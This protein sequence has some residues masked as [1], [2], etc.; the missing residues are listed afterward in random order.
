[1]LKFYFCTGLLLALYFTAFTQTNPVPQPLPYQQDFTALPATATTYPAGWQGWVL[2]PSTATQFRVTP[3]TGDKAL[4]ANGTAASTTGT[5]YNYNGKIGALNS[6][7]SGDQALVLAV[8]TTGQTGLQAGYTVMTI[9]NPYGGSNSRINEVVLQYRIGTTGN[10]TNVDG[11]LYQNNTTNQQS[12]TDPQNPLTVS[13]PLP[14]SCN[15]QP[16]VQL[17]WTSR[18]V[19]GSGSRPSFAIDNITIGNGS[20]GGADTTRPVV[21][22]LFPAT[23]ATGVPASAQP[24]IQFSE[25]VQKNTGVITVFDRTAQTS[26]TIAI[27]DSINAVLTGNTLAL[28]ARLKPLH[29][30]YILLDSAL[31]KDAAGNPFAGIRDSTAWTFT[32]GP[33]QLSFDFNNCSPNG[34]TTL[35]GGFIQYSVTGAQTWACTTFGQTGNGVEANGFANNAAQDNEDWLISP[36]FDFSHFH[37]PLL[38]FA[39]N[40]KFAGPALQL[41]V[42]T[43]YDGSS[44]PHNFTWTAVN[45]R[46]PG[47]NSAVWTTSD[48]INLS[49]FKAPGVYIAFVYRSSAAAGASRYT[50]DDVNITNSDTLPPPAFKIAPASVDFDY[51]AA[52]SQSAPQPFTLLAYNLRGDVVLTA[53]AGFTI[54]TDSTHFSSKLTLAKDSAESRS[55][56]LFARFTPTSADQDFKGT[57]QLQTIG[58]STPLLTLSGSSLRALK[59]VNWNVEWFGN[60]VNGPTNDSLQQQNVQTVLKNLNADIY[61]L[62]EVCDTARIKS[63]VA[64]MPGYSYVIADFGSYADNIYD[65]D[66][67]GAQKLAFVYKTSVV[68]RLQ[69]YGVLRSGGS[70]DAYYNWSSG[71]FPYLMKASVQLN[72][73]TAQLNLVLLHGKANTGTK[74]EKLEAWNRRKAAADELKDTLDTHFTY[75]NLVVLGD[76]N[77]A[78]NKTITTERLPDTTSSYS[79]FTADTTDYKFPTLPLSL[80]GDSSTVSNAN[81][82]DNVILS[83]EMGIAYVPA[84]AHVLYQAASLVSSYGTTTS[85]HYPVVSR[86]DVSY[87]AHPVP[88]TG[89]S[90]LADTTVKLS[91]YTPHEINSKYFIVERSHSNSS[92]FEP[93]DTLAGHAD[94]RERTNYATTDSKPFAGASYYRVKQVSADSS[95]SYSKVQAIYVQPAPRCLKVSIAGNQVTVEICSTFNGRGYIELIDM[96]GRVWLRLPIILFKGSNINRFFTYGMASGM[97]FVRIVQPDKAES[98]PVFIGH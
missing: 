35:D 28:H 92:G 67:A 37:Y 72:K 90:A 78:L 38:S 29:H 74:A 11:T 80:E 93:V 12:G 44:N 34:S 54:G 60:P 23:A 10:F 49:A 86:Y 52:G 31:V 7:S 24:S 19:S 36:S 14:D 42:S 39:S 51:V 43:D 2:A 21:T 33:Q 3:P 81:V 65:T 71:R 26:Q 8:N 6:S 47:V 13:V 16:V 66:Y 27:T 69:T 77:D 97:Y 84:S 4:T 56:T 40:S 89:F 87:I 32:M 62:A 22:S 68:T 45:G 9:R 70:G 18:E 91:W 15:N 17:R 20:S 5:I 53:P 41:L 83:N 79:S 85:D 96:Y 55:L 95:V 73:D 58:L 64:N 50:I 61:A 76:F 98:T 63:V 82:I 94:T 1:M 25:P 30:Y 59:I 88:V 75:Q 48:A 57:I 46:F